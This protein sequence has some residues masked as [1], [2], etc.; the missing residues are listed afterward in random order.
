MFTFLILLYIFSSLNGAIY[1]TYLWQLK[2]YRLDRMI[3]SMRTRSGLHKIMPNFQIV[4]VLLLAIGIGHFFFV[5]DIGI[6]SFYALLALSLELLEFLTRVISRQVFRPKKTTK[7]FLITAGTFFLMMILGLIV[8]Y[9]VL[10]IGRV[11]LYIL[12]ISI[13][14]GD[15]NSLVVFLFHP[16]TA[17][18]KRK[19][20]LNAKRKMAANKMKVIGI[21]GSYGKSST[22]EFLYQILESHYKGKV[23]KTP[24]NTNVDIGVAQEILKGLKT[25]HEYAIIEMGAYKKG[26]IKAICDIVHPD[27]GVVTAVAD[28][29]LAL[30]GS[31]KNIQE[32]KYE[33]IESL[34]DD[35]V[36]FFNNDSEG[37]SE[38]LKWA[39]GSDKKIISYACEGT[40]KVMA[41]HVNVKEREIDFDIH[42]VQ[43]MAPVFG[44]QNL[45]NLLSAISVAHECGMTL[46][47]I[48][49]AVRKIEMPDGIMCLKESVSRGADI[50]VIDD[51]YNANPDGVRAAL[52]Y[53]ANFKGYKKILIFPGMLELGA[54]TDIEHINVGEKIRAICDFSVF[55]SEDFLKPIMI[56]LG[57]DYDESKYIFSDSAEVILQAIKGVSENEKAVILFESRG[58]EAVMRELLK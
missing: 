48:S 51:S 41:L 21:T 52:D 20:I 49:K 33:L 7:A 26:E 40:A 43:F 34:G 24:G 45:P 9:S 38:L 29:H 6:F 32:A 19:V 3:D 42:G 55:T 13:L 54:K 5:K 25:E 30:F 22:K 15:L 17:H 36:A 27:I 47:E 39:S 58:A 50:F 44:K 57:Q 56:G 23:F 28:Q 35:G 31:L 1:Y 14:V 2:E 46:Q 4:K 12:V 37:A 11:A 8:N 10:E 16:I 18:M 53:L